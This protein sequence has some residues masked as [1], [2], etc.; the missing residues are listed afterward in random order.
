MRFRWVLAGGL[1]VAGAVVA[2]VVTDSDPR[3][4]QYCVAEVGDLRARTDL[5]QAK[6]TTLMSAI[7]DRR[8]LPPRATTIAIATAYQESR[9]HNIDYGDRDSLG[10][11]QQR[12]SQGWGAPEQVMDPTYAINRFYDGLVEVPN[13]TNLPITEAAQ[14]VQRSAYPEA[15]AD[16][17]PFARALAS[18][19]RGHSPASFACHINPVAGGSVPQIVS[20]LEN[21]YGPLPNEPANDGNSV[22]L[23]VSDA[24]EPAVRG[25]AL[26]HFLV[27]NAAELRIERIAFDG[28][29]WAADDY[30]GGW[31]EDADAPADAV[32][33]R[34]G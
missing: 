17:E 10:L 6:W 12:P 32:V 4:T 14:A 30:E 25:W 15:Y 20:A 19:Q 33:A 34:V 16:H 9:I 31:R 8:G 29:S 2:V 28:R 11:F 23:P 27:G 26:A 13:Y 24:A 21:A 7:A 18:A 5:E 1:L 3:R 22:R